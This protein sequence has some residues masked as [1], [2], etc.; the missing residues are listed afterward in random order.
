MIKQGL[1]KVEQYMKNKAFAARAPDLREAMFDG[2]LCIN[3]GA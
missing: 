3:L 2:K 1:V